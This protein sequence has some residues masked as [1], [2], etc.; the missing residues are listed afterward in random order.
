MAVRLNL[1][2]LAA[3]A[4]SLSLAGCAG[5]V[6]VGAPL[7]GGDDLGGESIDSDGGTPTRDARA[8]SSTDGAVTALPAKD[9]AAPVVTNPGS[10]AGTVTPNP[11]KDAGTTPVT[12]P[13]DAGTP[14]SGRD[15]STD[16]SKFLG[17]SRCPSS[18]VLFCDDFE[19]SAIGAP[20]PAN[21]WT[22]PTGFTAKVDNAHA[23]RGTKSLL[24]ATT[25]GMQGTLQ[26]KLSF[27]LANNTVYGRIFVW[28]EGLPTAPSDAHWVM[29]YAAGASTD[30]NK[31]QVRLDGQ[32]MNGA[33][34]YGIGSDGGD[35]GDWHT[36]GTE[37]QSVAA[38]KTWTC[39][40]WMFKGDTSETRVWIDGVEQTSLHT[41]SSSYR[42][43]AEGGKT[44]THP[45]YA[46]LS[47]GWWQY[48][49]GAPATTNVWIDEIM[50]DSARLGCV[51]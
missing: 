45:T 16:K 15:F 7:D 36:P 34:L 12:P 24:F 6:L 20:Q 37:P 42:R 3:V 35:S 13:P 33:N 30:A 27:P 22:S 10:D 26:P 29:A 11:G 41:T 51:F 5:N 38:E 4:L 47:L 49:A 31:G 28:I 18:G 50:F 2:S 17:A 44:F 14:P 1:L 32:L 39:L 46:N 40:E 9:G 25:S 21:L 43:G 19:N 23:A 8:A 48:V